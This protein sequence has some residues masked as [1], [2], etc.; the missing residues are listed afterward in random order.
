M[1]DMKK[2]NPD[3][4]ENVTG[5]TLSEFEIQMI[6]NFATL[7]TFSFEEVCRKMHIDDPED[8]E[9]ARRI[10]NSCKNNK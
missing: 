6:T 9:E 2:V 1:K 3:D 4:L 8:I 7:F 5:G 10:Y